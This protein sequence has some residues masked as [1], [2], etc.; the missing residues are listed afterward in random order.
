MPESSGDAVFYQRQSIRKA[1]LTAA[2]TREALATCVGL[3]DLYSWRLR[4][5]LS[6]LPVIAFHGFQ[7]ML[8]LARREAFKSHQHVPVA[9]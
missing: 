9:V 7:N 2:S 8:P 3:A 6:L 1:E 4:Q 5:S